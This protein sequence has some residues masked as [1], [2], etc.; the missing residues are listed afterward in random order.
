ML[1]KHHLVLDTF[2]EMADQLRPYADADFWD[3]AQH[4]PVPHSVTV[5]SRQTLNQHCKKIKELAQTGFFLPVLVNPTEGSQIIKSQCQRLGLLELIQ[6]GQFLI[7]G[8]GAI[9]PGLASMWYDSYR[10]KPYD[11]AENLQACEQAQAIFTQLSK[12]YDFLFLNGRTRPHRKYLI[13][14]LKDQGLLDRALWSCLDATPVPGAINYYGELCDRPT[15]LRLLPPEYE[16]PQYQHGI[17]SQYLRRFVKDELFGNTWG[18]IYLHA[19]PYV[20]TYFSLVSET[21]FEYPHSLRSEKIYKPIAIGHPFVAAANQGFYY[22]LHQ[23]GF[24]TFGHLIDERFDQIENNQDRLK[25]IAQV[26]Q[27]LCKQN[28]DDF[29]VA[30]QEI[31]VYNQQHMRE[32]APKIKAE[33]VPRFLEFIDCWKHQ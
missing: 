28:L 19:P 17:K 4:E 22:D 7:V 20:D 1:G 25:R 30:A 12:P 27:D 9:E 29:V 3:F 16:V 24:R 15:D 23:A 31:C 5:I 6:N 13:E 11:Y 33:F 8:C 18:E 26:V 32:T 14:L 21:V 2:C 10:Y